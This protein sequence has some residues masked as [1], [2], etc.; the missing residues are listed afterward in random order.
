MSWLRIL[1]HRYPRLHESTRGLPVRD[2]NLRIR[3]KLWLSCL[4]S[5]WAFCYF[6]WSRISEIILWDVLPVCA[7]LHTD[8]NKRLKENTHVIRIVIVWKLFPEVVKWGSNPPKLY[9]IVEDAVRRDLSSLR[10]NWTSNKFR[11]PDLVFGDGLVSDF[12]YLISKSKRCSED[13]ILVFYLS[14]K[15]TCHT[16]VIKFSCPFLMKFESKTQTDICL[17]E[18]PPYKSSILRILFY[19]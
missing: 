6:S 11:S 17:F 12:Y 16:P 1:L 4:Q 13:H 5:M 3:W 8:N 18:S 9:G 2:S 15:Q 7:C 14:L 19:W 10:N